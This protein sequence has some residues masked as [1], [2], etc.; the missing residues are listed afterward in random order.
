MHR[1]WIISAP[2]LLLLAA[3]PADP[4][5]VDTDGGDT[6]PTTGVGPTT[7]SATAPTTTIDPGTDSGDDLPATDDAPATDGPMTTASDESTT[8]GP[9]GPGTCGNNVVEGAEVCD[10]VQLNGETCESQGFEGGTLGCLLNCTDYN[11]DGCFICG[12]GKVEQKE[13]CEIDPPKGVDCEGLGFPEGG[14]VLCN[15][16]CMFDTSECQVCGDGIQQGFED[17]DDM[18][19]GGETCETLG[20][21]MG[22]LACN[23]GD[24]GYDYSGCSGGQYIQDFEG[25]VAMPPEFTLGGTQV[26]TLDM[27]VPLAGLG[28]ARSGAITHS[29]NSSMSLDVLFAIDGTVSFLHD[30]D[31]ENSFDYL[32][33]YIDG[34]LDTSWSGQN[35]PATY[36]TVIPSGP[37][38]L[39]WRYIKDGSVNVGQDAVWVDDIVL[40][41]GVPV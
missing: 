41:G 20:F 37:H 2:A 7:A 38:T 23:A 40:F 28:S 16:Q 12:N 1:R 21:D 17:C 29:Q 39:E 18:D 10:L 11:I 13:D 15:A 19:L 25:I 27:A 32:Q 22:T 35:A 31:S 26:W 36:M 6:N 34:V 30:E 24:C 4:V 9:V 3:C 33:F 8:T 14:I 5:E